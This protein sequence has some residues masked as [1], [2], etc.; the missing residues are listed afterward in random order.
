I[1]HGLAEKGVA[2]RSPGDPRLLP[3]GGEDRQQLL[4][5]GVVE[6]GCIRDRCESPHAA[7]L[8]TLELLSEIFL[9]PSS[10]AST[11]SGECRESRSRRSIKSANKRMLIFRVSR[12]GFL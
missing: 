11:R 9:R 3:V 6:P 10:S 12:P 2:Y 1:G 8:S 7:N 4:Q 5:P